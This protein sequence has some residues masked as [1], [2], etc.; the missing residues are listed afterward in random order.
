[1]P[2]TDVKVMHSLENRNGDNFFSLPQ[3]TG[4]SQGYS[5]EIDL[6]EIQGKQYTVIKVFTMDSVKYEI[7]YYTM[8]YLST[9]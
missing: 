8:W 5:C 3:N 6:L 2:S 4:V 9:F 7:N 1:M